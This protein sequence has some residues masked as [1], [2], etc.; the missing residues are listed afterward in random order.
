ME[1]ADALCH[2]IGIVSRGRLRCVGTQLDLK[3]RFGSG[4]KLSV[5]T[6]NQDSASNYI[7]SL[8]PS[9]VLETV[10]SGTLTFQI[11]SGFD[12]QVLF[13]AMRNKAEYHITSW[14]V[15]QTSLEDVFLRIVRM[16]EEAQNQAA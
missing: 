7:T 12:L 16:E 11:S 6:T 5:T 2:R 1:E 15:N 9:A 14:A 4:Y 3:H 10:Y 13:E 8:F